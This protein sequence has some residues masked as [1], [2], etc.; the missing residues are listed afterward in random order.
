MADSK[1]PV[2][3][4]IRKNLDDAFNPIH[5]EVIN[6]SHKHNVPK[7]SETH[8]K[9]VVVS[10]EFEKTKTLIQRHRLVNDA[11]SKQLEGPVHALS[12]VAKT[13]AQ[14]QKMVDAGEKI[15]PSPACRGGDGSLPSN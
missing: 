14:W 7:D 15:E 3:A 6:E 9:V 13:P 4:A 12:I 10:P 11:L 1:F 2:T 5:L 8:F